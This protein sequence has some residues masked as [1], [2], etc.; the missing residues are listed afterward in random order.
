MLVLPL[1][2]LKNT[3]ALFVNDVEFGTVLDEE[4][5]GVVLTLFDRVEDRCLSVIVH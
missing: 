5:N 2:E 1:C 4:F 3:H